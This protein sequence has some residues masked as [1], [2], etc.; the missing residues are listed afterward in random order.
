MEENTHIYQ[1]LYN[2][3]LLLSQYGLYRGTKASIGTLA[4]LVLRKWTT[5]IKERDD[6]SELDVCEIANIVDDLE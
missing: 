3:S 2:S 4:I 6:K 5:P 1:T